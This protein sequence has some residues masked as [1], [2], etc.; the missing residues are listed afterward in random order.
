MWLYS[1]SSSAS[2]A[3]VHIEIKDIVCWEEQVK[4]LN[5]I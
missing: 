2:A 1:S 5:Q 4:I 3:P